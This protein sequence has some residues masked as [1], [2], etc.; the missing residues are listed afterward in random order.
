MTD[1]YTMAKIWLKDRVF[2]IE[3]IL[4]DAGSVVNLALI[5]VIRVMGATL[6][7]TKDP[8]IRIVASNLVHLDFNVDLR[9]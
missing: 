1:F 6:I 5:S 4:I 7:P 2:E 3:H 9:W 8:I